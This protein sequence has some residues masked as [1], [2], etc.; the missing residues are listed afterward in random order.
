MI[1][2]D[3]VHPML[4][5]FPIVLFVSAFII[6]L[7]LILRG[8]DLA[9]RRPLAN[10]ALGL[11]I[12]AGTMAVV[13]A[14]FGDIALE[15]ALAKGFPEAPLEQHEGFGWTTAYA[16]AGYALLRLLAHWRRFSL[17]GLRGWATTAVTAAGVVLLLTTAFYGGKLVYEHGVNVAAVHP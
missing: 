13:A 15:D 12:A 4:V 9:A 16:F 14:I 2:I 5:H 11:L 10:L 8:G 3:Y 17:A 1:E 6:D 7:F